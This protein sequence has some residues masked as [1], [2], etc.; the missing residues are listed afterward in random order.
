MVS[1]IYKHV[2]CVYSTNQRENGMMSFP[3]II[4]RNQ[5]GFI[6][7]NQFKHQIIKRIFESIDFEVT[8]EIA[9]RSSVTSIDVDHSQK[10]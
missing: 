8:D 6:K 4:S 3:E 9:L 10:L 2:V 5:N 1:D 7:P